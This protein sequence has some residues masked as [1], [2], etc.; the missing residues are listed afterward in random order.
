[1]S[2]SDGQSRRAG[3]WDIVGKG[4]V[5]MAV[6]GGDDKDTDPK[7]IKESGRDGLGG[8]SGREKCGTRE[9]LSTSTLVYRSSSAS[10]STTTNTSTTSHSSFS[11]AIT[12]PTSENEPPYPTVIPPQ[13]V[14]AQTA[15]ATPEDGKDA[16]GWM[17]PRAVL[18]S[19]GVA[20]TRH[21]QANR[22]RSPTGMGASGEVRQT[23][24][25]QFVVCGECSGW[26]RR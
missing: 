1:M 26:C 3:A 18:P 12:H 19:A 2:P 7:H 13:H 25:G 17:A 24:V 15:C 23:T 21:V 20:M 8:G 6:F 16:S 4:N 11:S 22:A 9:H 10:F 5:G 14:P